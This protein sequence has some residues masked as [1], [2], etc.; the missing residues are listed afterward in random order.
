LQPADPGAQIDKPR[1]NQMQ[2]FAFLLQGL[3]TSSSQPSKRR[4]ADSGNSLS[5]N[6]RGHLLTCSLLR[7]FPDGIIHSATACGGAANH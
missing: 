6:S 7:I 3:L 2:D 5:S 4:A 1:G